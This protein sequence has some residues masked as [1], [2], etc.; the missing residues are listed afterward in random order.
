MQETAA[1]LTHQAR[2]VDEQKGISKTFHEVTT[3]S[4]SSLVPAT[5]EFH[6]N[7]QYYQKALASPIGQKV[8]SF[9]TNTSKEVIDI[10]E[11]ARRIADE[12]KTATTTPPAS[13][14]PPPAPTTQAAPTVV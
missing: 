13:G 11:E 4:P 12:N 5:D 7:S 1:S 10:H 8:M 14:Q 3:L 9:Y 6:N 2:S